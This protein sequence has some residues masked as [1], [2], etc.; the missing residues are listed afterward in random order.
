MNEETL[1][2]IMVRIKLIIALFIISFVI[3]SF[4]PIISVAVYCD[5]CDEDT[6]YGV[7]SLF[8]RVVNPDCPRIHNTKLKDFEKQEY[9]DYFDSV[10]HCGKIHWFYDR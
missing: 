7:S 3:L 10:I 4:M 1:K 9:V 5:D 6:I 8:Q 2:Y